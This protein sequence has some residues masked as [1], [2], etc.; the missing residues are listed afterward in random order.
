MAAVD[1]AVAGS[2]TTAA[3]AAAQ[4]AALTS[5]LIATANGGGTAAA[6]LSALA[7]Q[8]ATNTTG[9]GVMIRAQLE[10]AA[11][12]RASTASIAE[13]QAAM[14]MI[15]ANLGGIAGSSKT[16][17]ILTIDATAAIKAE[18]A[19]L[20][21][22]AAASGV[23]ADESV[24]AAY[25]SIAGYEA[26]AAAIMAANVGLET[27]IVLLAQV[28][29]ELKAVIVAQGALGT[30]PSFAAA[31]TA[32]AMLAGIENQITALKAV[33][34]VVV[35]AAAAVDTLTAAEMRQAAALS[36]VNSQIGGF[37]SL[38]SKFIPLAIVAGLALIAGEA[39]HTAAQLK[40]LSD[41]LGIGIEDM[42]VM[43]F[44][45]AKVGFNI[46]AL[47]TMFRMLARHI[48]N[49]LH[50]K[51]QE[52]QNLK[53][54]LHFE[55]N[56]S[57]LAYLQKYG[58]DSSKVL[59]DLATELDKT[60]TSMERQAK[61]AEVLGRSGG[62]GGGGAAQL[63]AFMHEIAGDN[64]AK[65]TEEARRLGVVVNEETGAAAVKFLQTWNEVKLSLMGV[66][67]TI[68]TAIL[69][70]LQALGTIMI[71]MSSGAEVAPWTK[72]LSPL[73]MIAGIIRII[74]GGIAT[75]VGWIEKF[76][77]GLGILISKAMNLFGGSGNASGQLTGRTLALTGGSAAYSYS[78]DLAGQYRGV[79]NR[80]A[81]RVGAIF[82]IGAGQGPKGGDS[83][84]LDPSESARAAQ[85]AKDR[86]AVAKDQLAVAQ[87][88]LAVQGAS[89]ALDEIALQH[90]VKIAD[91]HREAQQQMRNVE[92]GSELA[93]TISATES[94]KIAAEAARYVIAKDEL[95]TKGREELRILQAQASVQ[96]LQVIRAGR[97]GTLAKEEIDY[98][99]KSLEIQ[100]RTTAAVDALENQKG[101]K[102]DINTET[103]IAA[104]QT[105]AALDQQKAERE[106][107]LAIENE[108]T[109]RANNLAALTLAVD[110]SKR[111]LIVAKDSVEEE[112]IRGHA[113][114]TRAD[115]A[116]SA[117][118]AISSFESAYQTQRLAAEQAADTKIKALR[119]DVAASLM[120]AAFGGPGALQAVADAADAL[121]Q[122]DKLKATAA[123]EDLARLTALEGKITGVSIDE[124]RK[125]ANQ[126]RQFRG[127]QNL[128]TLAEADNLAHLEASVEKDVAKQSAL[129]IEAMK[130]D[131]A[132][133]A[134][135][136]DIRRWQ[137]LGQTIGNALV[138]GMNDILAGAKFKDVLGSFAK[139][140][141][142]T[143]GAKFKDS[144][145][146]W[147][148]DLAIVAS[149]GQTDR[150]KAGGAAPFM[151]G[152]A[153]QAQGTLVGAQ[154]VSAAMNLYAQ[155]Q[156]GASK[157]QNA[158][159]GAS[160]GASIGMAAGPWGAVAGAVIGA[161][162]GYVFAAIASGSKARFQVSVGGDGKIS[163]SGFGNASQ[164][165]IDSAVRNL[166]QTLK[167]S[168]D[169]INAILEA[170]PRA[171]AI[172]LGAI[173]PTIISPGI[174]GDA[175]E[176]VRTF[177]ISIFKKSFAGGYT[178]D[179][180][181]HFNDVELPQ[182]VFDAY[183]PILQSGLKQLGVTEEKLKE[184]FAQGPG[185][186]PKQGLQDILDYVTV[187]TNFVKATQRLANVQGAL[188]DLSTARLDALGNQRPPGESDFVN[189][190]RLSA[191]AIFA[192]LATDGVDSLAAWK[193]I[194]A[195]VE[196]VTRS[197]TD[198]INHLADVQRALDE[199]FIGTQLEHDLSRA[200]RARDYQ[201]NVITPTSEGNDAFAAAAK[202]IAGLN[203]LGSTHGSSDFVANLKTGTESIFQQAQAMVRMTGPDRANAWKA[204]GLSVEQVT[205]SLSDY[206]AHIAEVLKSLN[207]S[208]QQ[209]LY[210][211]KLAAAGEVK[212]YSGEILHADDPNA[213]ARIMEAEY[214]RLMAE[215]QNAKTLGISADQVASDT[216]AA[217]GILR[218][219]FALDPT[220]AAEDWYQKQMKILAD[221]SEKSVK[222]LGEE[223]RT[224][225]QKLLSELTPF[226]DFFK[227]LPV[228][229][230][231][232]IALLTG[233]GGAFPGFADALNVLI[234]RMNG[235]LPGSGAEGTSSLLTGEYERIIKQIQNAASL[236]LT[237][238]QVQS[239]T[240]R[241]MQLANQLY[242][243]DPTDKMDAW[244]QGQMTFLAQISKEALTALGTQASDAV[245]KMLAELKP[246]TDYFKGL[247][248]DLAA[249]TALLTGPGGVFAGFADALAALTE[250]VKNTIGGSPVIPP[251]GTQPPPGGD[252]GDKG[253]ASSITITVPV[254]LNMN[255][256]S[257][258]AGDLVAAAAAAAEE[259]V[260]AAIKAYPSLIESSYAPAGR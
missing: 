114:Q 15:L 168:V 259:G 185:F 46:D 214:N 228:D 103:K 108:A 164:S 3:T 2:G 219:I 92:A 121:A 172:Q 105:S 60:T 212:G 217:M 189:S 206:V 64:W 135:Q 191:E 218:S 137:D 59:R 28:A 128:E 36:G 71:S 90:A 4:Q 51:P 256:T 127:N 226:T 202:L 251:I 96:A 21:Q 184:L 246:F 50:G 136:K 245:A 93:R 183:A 29:R 158:L 123:N 67:L 238:D 170:F 45:A 65:A 130:A 38:A 120:V 213:R 89:N 10:Q 9:V 257:I 16:A 179:Q 75:M 24:T 244:W 159:T 220:Q 49:A 122:I 223:A 31:G 95:I 63:P 200:G 192:K 253:K 258:G 94:T 100:N 222:S 148:D 171:I 134:A 107:L 208:F 80:A 201:G 138:T 132:L 163:V 165:D 40:Y 231:A 25:E 44:A 145:T 237:P 161:A 113:I 166:N 102:R 8:Y 85:L 143:I 116:R 236:G 178:A 169:S 215:I 73:N 221:E 34:A 61:I 43:N 52:L 68:T 142:A 241:A 76:S 99:I 13:Q 20:E 242:A 250:R 174:I 227:G 139:S 209:S 180:L 177:R 198:F 230:G 98:R 81:D 240:A 30:E 235:E 104:L 173:D 186:D 160:A 117:M 224:A 207:Q 97:I 147:M 88:Q 239:L 12:I 254:T 190:V 18:I 205:K 153:N 55:D 48:D 140:I 33:P 248:V 252:G 19:A 211:H 79:E 232:A 115:I 144:L 154:V 197:L 152:S 131:I 87:A 133:E 195:S 157:G 110:A 83:G 129:D 193:D 203:D 1:A 78:K 17:T 91:I 210:E 54:A 77:T 69:P 156:A 53:E 37:V 74:A 5:S 58:G 188:G 11:A 146:K 216:T 204:L 118:I 70:A 66:G 182:M 199:A 35:P 149:G 72:W 176:K 155:A 175:V 32:G 247:P 62:G 125:R 39:I 194:S 229:L 233:P 167:Q 86:L 47:G 260:I 82:G 141:T 234:A 150:M 187:L 225:V 249:A 101:G 42:S 196:Q 109:A 181:K 56:K 124:E 26:E 14:Q 162:Y 106:H 243:N 6:S 255:G 23:A 41:R 57:V 112:I 7:Q 84:G 151:G 119:K 27:Q 126:F 22:L 111:D